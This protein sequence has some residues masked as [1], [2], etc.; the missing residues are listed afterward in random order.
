MSIEEYTERILRIARDERRRTE[1]EI[2]AKTIQVID[3]RFSALKTD[4]RKQIETLNKSSPPT[5]DSPVRAYP[6]ETL[7]KDLNNKQFRRIEQ[8][9]KEWH[10]LRNRDS[11]KPFNKEFS[12]YRHDQLKAKDGD[13]AERWLKDQII[14]GKK[15]N[16]HSIDEWTKKPQMREYV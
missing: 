9:L 13:K 6:A 4:V 11:F 12:L 16:H 3:S 7:L 1:E 10:E 5:L 15:E 8:L 14:Q 2:Y